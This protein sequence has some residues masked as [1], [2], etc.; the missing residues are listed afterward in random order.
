MA[1]NGFIEPLWSEKPKTGCKGGEK[2]KGETLHLLLGALFGV[3]EDGA[4]TT[5]VNAV[6]TVAI[7][8][9][10]LV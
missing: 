3:A 7:H 10:V 2:R 1:L 6:W 4:H 5:R 9:S 8:Y